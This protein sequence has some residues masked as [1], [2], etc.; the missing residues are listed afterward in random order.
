MLFH[1]KI[2]GDGIS[3]VFISSLANSGNVRGIGSRKRIHSRV[4]LMYRGI[5][6]RF[7]RF[8]HRFPTSVAVHVVF[9]S[10]SKP[11]RRPVYWKWFADDTIVIFFLLCRLDR[12]SLFLVV[13]I[14]SIRALR[15]RREG[16]S[17][18]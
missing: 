4:A 15:G 8:S 11:Y 3:Y 2:T 6:F 10:V 16:E 1:L 13:R 9:D 18:S 7:E 17:D 14:R 12:A 5:G